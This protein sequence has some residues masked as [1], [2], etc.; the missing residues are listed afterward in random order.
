MALASDAARR[1]LRLPSL[2]SIAGAGAA[3]ERKLIKTDDVNLGEALSEA[4]RSAARELRLPTEGVD[5]TYCDINGERYR[6]EEWGF[7]LLKVPQVFR[8]TSYVAPADC[9][10]DVGAAS[11]PLLCTLAV[12]SWKRGY[13]AGPRALVFAGSENGLRGAVVLETPPSRA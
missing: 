13:A 4:V 1:Q 2:G 12:Q 6:S 11:G 10:G 8:D 5:A 3:L 7:V 9:W